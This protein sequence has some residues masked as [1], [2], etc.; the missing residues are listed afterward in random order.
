MMNPHENTENE[1]PMAS[2]TSH[3]FAPP[4]PAR[5]AESA[6]TDP[7]TTDPTTTDP[8]WSVTRFPRTHRRKRLFA[9]AGVFGAGVLVA[10]TA[11]VTSALTN[12]SA[13]AQARAIDVQGQAAAPVPA[14]VP[15]GAVRDLRAGAVFLQSNDVTGNQVV[16]LSR[17]DDGSLKEVGRYPTGGSGTGSFEDSAQGLVIGTSKGVTS[18]TRVVADA[19]LLFVPN[20]GSGTITVFRIRANGLERVALVPSGGSRPVSLAVSNGL[21]YVL[22]SGEVDRRLLLGG[23]G[24]LE[25]CAHG[26]LPSVTGFR[27]SPEGDL[28][29]IANSQRQLSGKPDSGCAEV[30]FTPNGKTLVVTERVANVAKK[31]GAIN[32]YPVNSDGTLGARRTTAPVGAGPFGFTFTHDGTLITSEQNGGYTH[33]G[34]GGAATYTLKDGVPHPIGADVPDFQTDSCWVVVT[35]DERF[36]FVSSPFEG[37]SISSYSVAANGQLTLAYPSATSAD[38]N[39]VTNNY[40]S[41]GVTDLALSQDSGFLYQLNSFEGVLYSFKVEPNGLLTPLATTKVF[42]IAPFGA[43]G[44][45]APFGIAAR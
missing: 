16:A 11:L 28:T 25:N 32:T 10:V 33:P 24:A 31:A 44:Q 26:A 30:A 12:G 23:D 34:A 4:P 38:G 45:A 42:D 8:L 14:A 39:D 36:A 35:D 21:L 7:T 5:A 3:A 40:V 29:P 6:M 9:G 41:D 18:P 1:P 13:P 43:G 15:V 22:N 37:G 2:P 19:E 17:K 20:A 27:V